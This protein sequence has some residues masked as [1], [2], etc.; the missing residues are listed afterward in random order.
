MRQFVRDQRIALEVEMRARVVQRAVGLRRRRRVFHPAENKIADRDLRILGVRIGHADHALEK[1]DHLRRVAKR[2]ARIVLAAGRNVVG[3]GSVA[4]ALFDHREL[5]GRQRDQIRR[6]RH[7]MTPVKGAG[8]RGGIRGRADEAAVGNRGE[9]FGHGRD[10]FAGGPIVGVVVAGKPVA[11]VLVFALRPRLPRLVRIAVVGADKIKS[12]ARLTR[13]VD[14][15]LDF[16]AGAE[17]ARQRNPQLAVGGLE[18]R[19]FATARAQLESRVR[20]R[21]TRG[22]RAGR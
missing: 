2:A 7:V 18:G 12:A 9:F 20:W 3:D 22:D 19:G 10:D 6:V 17:R 15:D 11:R 8:L 21:R 4:G 14:R 5:T 1:L 13:V 16:L